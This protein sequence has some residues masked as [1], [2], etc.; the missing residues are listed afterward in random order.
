VTR[1]RPTEPLPFDDEPCYE[2]D[3]LVELVEFI[4]AARIQC[5]AV[6]GQSDFDGS[7]ML[8]PG[9]ATA[10]IE[11]QLHKLVA[12][13]TKCGRDLGEKA[14]DPQYSIPTDAL[15]VRPMFDTGGP[16]LQHVDD[17]AHAIAR[18][19]SPHHT[20]FIVGDTL[21]YIR[22]DGAVK[23][24]KGKLLGMRLAQ[25]TQT[26]TGKRYV[27]PPA[28]IMQ[29]IEQTAADLQWIPRLERVVTVP[30]FLNDGTLLDRPGYHEQSLTYYAPAL[31]GVGVPDAVTEVDVKNAVQL[32]VDEY[33]GDIAFAGQADRANTIACMLLP[34][35]RTLIGP[36]P[37]HVFDAPGM[38]HGKTQTLVSALLPGCG[39]VNP[40]SWSHSGAEQTKSLLSALR[41][42]PSAMFIDNVTGTVQSET[43]EAMLTSPW[44]FYTNR[45]LG[46]TRDITV[47]VH[48]TWAMS[49]NNGSMGN[50]G[51]A[52]RVLWARIDAGTDDPDSR[53]GPTPGE[54]WRHPGGLVEWGEAHRAELVNACLVIC[55]WWFQNDAPEGVMPKGCTLG[56]FERY[57]GVIGGVLQWAGIEGFSA[58]VKERRQLNDGRHEDTKLFQ[59]L[60]D[61][62]DENEFNAAQCLATGAAGEMSA[63]GFGQVLSSKVDVISGGLVL[64]KRFDE[65]SKS[66]KYHIERRD[67]A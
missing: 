65:S 34:F 51:M 37:L 23:S 2:H 32:L 22:D 64:R 45:V 29:A 18:A 31:E 38:G 17:Y 41:K 43:L 35:V 6:T 61:L 20:V 54:S 49:T 56:S 44:G 28:S 13:C 40:T 57:Q 42:A 10:R 24:L 25:V 53:T 46:E 21:S 9:T 47:P 8:C 14:G 67:S 50:T 5:R 52:R 66:G 12:E 15:I 48:Q 19:E 59:Q 7:D 36:T 11:E 60:L 16:V 4:E 58:N 1:E 26:R 33:L 30:V 3:E 62:F 55:R 27:D 63:K 39:K